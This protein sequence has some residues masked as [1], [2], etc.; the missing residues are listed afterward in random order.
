[1]PASRRS[2]PWHRRIRHWLAGRWRGSDRKRPR[3]RLR[4]SASNPSTS[5]G[6]IHRH[7]EARLH[8]G[9]KS[10]AQAILPRISEVAHRLRKRL[11]SKVARQ[12]RHRDGTDR[13]VSGQFLQLTAEFGT[14]STG[15]ALLQNG[16]EVAD[17][18]AFRHS[19]SEGCNVGSATDKCEFI[20]PI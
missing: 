4:T 12:F 7:S 13:T 20:M 19:I 16:N 15:G 10:A 14:C 3:Y 8:I 5:T 18:L 9:V 11:G 17:V 6:P 1:M 2:A